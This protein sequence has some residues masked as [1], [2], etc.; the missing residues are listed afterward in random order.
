[1]LLKRVRHFLHSKSHIF[2]AGC[3]QLAERKHESHQMLV[4]TVNFIAGIRRHGEGEQLS[5]ALLLPQ[6]HISVMLKTDDRVCVPL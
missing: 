1:M 2:D 4:D 5:E 6:A 3:A